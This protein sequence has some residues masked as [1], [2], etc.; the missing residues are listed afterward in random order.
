[1]NHSV[2]QNFP[3]IG[4]EVIPQVLLGQVLCH[5]SNGDPAAALIL[6][7]VH[8]ILTLRNMGQSSVSHVVLGKVHVFFV[9]VLN[10]S[11]V[12]YLD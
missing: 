6:L 12:G 10:I 5:W 9:L 1:M 11:L 7:A 4:H 8:L 2:S 3:N